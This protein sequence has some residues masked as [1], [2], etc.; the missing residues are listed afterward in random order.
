MI[1][2]GT[3]HRPNKLGGYD[4]ITL[5][6]LMGLVNSWLVN[7]QPKLVISGMALGWDQAIASAAYSLGIPFH[8]YVPFEG[9]ESMWPRNSQEDYKWLLSKASNVV[10]T[11]E[12]GYAAWKMQHRNERMVDACDRVLALWD[13][14]KGGTGNCIAYAEK[15]GKPIINL[16]EEYHNNKE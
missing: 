3:G 8:A 13:G 6:R 2:A 12:P 16:W 15:V 14:S 11:A 1:I 10:Y 7:Y 9:Q 5:R 4:N